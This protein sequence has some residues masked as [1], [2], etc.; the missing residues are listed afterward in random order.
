MKRPLVGFFDFAC[1]EGCQLQVANMGE[2]LLDVLDVVDVVEFREVMS[3][4]WDREL[5]YRS[6]HV[7]ELEARL[8]FATGTSLA[9]Q[10][11][12]HAGQRAWYVDPLGGGWVE[13]QLP[14]FF[15]L[16]GRLQQEVALDNRAALWAYLQVHNALDVEHVEGSF[17]PQPGRE[18]QAGMG[19]DF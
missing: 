8:R 12:W 3:E 18:V 9:A 19:V 6:P 17:S 14:G 5:D 15:L 1:C 11:A 10:A 13:E 4:R 16:H 2:Q 7:G